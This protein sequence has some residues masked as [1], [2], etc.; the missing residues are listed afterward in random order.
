[1][2]VSLNKIF[3]ITLRV[4]PIQSNSPK[5]PP[6]SSLKK[7]G[8]LETKRNFAALNVSLAAIKSVSADEI[9]RSQQQEQEQQETW[10]DSIKDS[11]KIEHSCFAKYSG[12]SGRL[13]VENEQ[14]VFYQKARIGKEK[15]ICFPFS[16]ITKSSLVDDKDLHILSKG[17][18]IVFRGICK[19][20]MFKMN[21]EFLMKYGQ[22]AKMEPQELLQKEIKRWEKIKTSFDLLKVATIK[23]YQKGD[24][25]LNF[26]NA[27][28][29]LHQIQSGQCHIITYLTNGEVID[30]K[31]VGE[32]YFIGHYSFLCGEYSNVSAVALSE[33][34]VLS[35]HRRHFN[36]LK[37]PADG[38][39]LLA[40][41]LQHIIEDID[42]RKKF[43]VDGV[44]IKQPRSRMEL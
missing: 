33:C 41:L 14:I 21:T 32:G 7:Q 36:A 5:T 24:Y 3:I 13:C 4:R 10:W 44:A 25:I 17:K 8:S 1:L 11:S 12:K 43:V 39:S 6:K 23:R 31:T 18:N 20:E 9:L 40:V 37:D 35:I 27:F 38:S 2:Q 16:S 30:E 34:T 22:V 19:S 15:K 26:G 29:T 28:Q 42:N